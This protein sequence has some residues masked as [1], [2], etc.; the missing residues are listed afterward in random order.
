MANK[1]TT[2][3]VVNKTIFCPNK[4]QTIR[5]DGTVIKTIVETPTGKFDNF[6]TGFYIKIHSHANK[7]TEDFKVYLSASTTL[8]LASHVLDQ[9]RGL[10][11]TNFEALTGTGGLNILRAGMFGEKM[12]VSISIGDANS[13]APLDGNGMRGFAELLKII[14]ASVEAKMIDTKS[15]DDYRK[16]KKQQSRGS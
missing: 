4:E 13:F 14:V 3:T 2:R 6:D 10:V 1:S 7:D 5:I 8:S 9:M 11:S 15:K 16:W 12:G